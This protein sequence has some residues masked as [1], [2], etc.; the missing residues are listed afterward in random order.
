MSRGYTALGYRQ[1]FIITHTPQGGLVLTFEGSLHMDEAARITVT[2]EH[3][4]LS[5][6]AVRVEAL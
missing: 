4:W 3:F 2:V 6:K 5:V 1:F